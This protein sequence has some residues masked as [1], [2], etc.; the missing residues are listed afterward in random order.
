MKRITFVRPPIKI[1][2]GLDC[3]YGDCSEETRHRTRMVYEGMYDV[4]QAAIYNCVYIFGNHRFDL[5][6]A[7]D[8]IPHVVEYAFGDVYLFDHE[9]SVA[10][11]APV[12][13]GITAVVKDIYIG[14]YR[15]ADHLRINGYLIEDLADILGESDWDIISNTNIEL[16]HSREISLIVEQSLPENSGY[17]RSNANR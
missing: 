16:D 1:D 17:R 6:N 2:I 7:I 10:E 12:L 8:H 15:Y 13:E 9:L 3:F 14:L 5:R 4:V 11:A